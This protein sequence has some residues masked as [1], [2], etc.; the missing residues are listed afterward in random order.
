MCSYANGRANGYSNGHAGNGYA[1]GHSFSTPA[2]AA[3]PVFT[4]GMDP[5]EAQRLALAAASARRQA[6][7]GPHPQ[8]S[9]AEEERQL[10]LAIDAS[11]QEQRA[12]SRRQAEEAQLRAAIDASLRWGRVAACRALLLAGA[13]VWCKRRAARPC[14]C[15]RGVCL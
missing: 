3:A 13:C 8:L 5:V 4:P 2:P 1:N 7:G 14:C 12:A 15:L 9:A 11:L 6:R 10:R